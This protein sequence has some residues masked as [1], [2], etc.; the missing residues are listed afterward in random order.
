[1]NGRRYKYILSIAV[2]VAVGF[3]LLI[4]LRTI[5]YN[6]NLKKIRQSNINLNTN[7]ILSPILF[8]VG[9][10][11]RIFQLITNP[12][13]TFTFIDVKSGL[14]CDTNLTKL[15]CSD[16]FINLGNKFN[17][18]KNEFSPSDLV[19][20]SKYTIIEHKYNKDINKKNNILDFVLN[21]WT[22]KN[23][24]PNYKPYN[25]RTSTI[26]GYIEMLKDSSIILGPA[27]K[28]ISPPN[29]LSIICVFSVPNN[30]STFNILHVFDIKSPYNQVK[31][32]NKNSKFFLDINN[33][34]LGPVPNIN[35]SPNMW[36]CISATFDFVNNTFNIFQN[37]CHVITYNYKNYKDYDVKLIRPRFEIFGVTFN[38]FE[39]ISETR[40]MSNTEI[41]DYYNNIFNI[42]NLCPTTISP[43]T[44][45]IPPTTTTMSTTRHPITTARP[46]TRPPTTTCTTIQKCIEIP[47]VINN[48]ENI[49]NNIPITTN[50]PI[51]VYEKNNNSFLVSGYSSE[52][53]KIKNTNTQILKL[54][55]TLS[56]DTEIK[57]CMS[58]S[59]IP[60]KV[61]GIVK[62]NNNL[63]EILPT[64]TQRVTTS[65][66]PPTTTSRS[67]RLPP[68]FTRPPINN[69]PSTIPP[70]ISSPLIFEYYINSNNYTNI[71]RINNIKL[72]F[73]ENQG[74]INQTL[75]GISKNFKIEY[76]SVYQESFSEYT[77][78]FVLEYN[79]NLLIL[80]LTMGITK[81]KYNLTKYMTSCVEDKFWLQPN[82]LNIYYDSKGV[83][84][85][86]FN[87]RVIMPNIEFEDV[88]TVTNKGTVQYKTNITPGLYH[89]QLW[90]GGQSG[91]E[92]TQSFGGNG[93]EGGWY[94]SRYIN[95]SN[96]SELNIVVGK[97]GSG[98]IRGGTTGSGGN[99]SLTYSVKDRNP[100]NISIIASGGGI[101]NVSGTMITG[102]IKGTVGGAGGF[103]N[104]S[105]TPGS[106]FPNYSGKNLPGNG[107]GNFVKGFIGGGGGGGI[108]W[109]GGNGGNGGNYQSFGFS[110]GSGGGGS[111]YVSG[112]NGINGPVKAPGG[113]GG[114]GAVIIRKINFT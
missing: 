5:N 7:T 37:G 3:I 87:N 21:K 26:N 90:G 32:I 108:S 99:T 103:N 29:T 8:K 44:T 75:K 62:Y 67:T 72:E 81:I 52:Y 86:N 101:G 35:I 58:S 110:G 94:T 31:F 83:P 69:I 96:N 80:D 57:N 46:T 38:I 56:K 100:S 85:L 74:V 33:R 50:I 65:T 11:E 113:K 34:E 89:V 95:L 43:T 13:N 102:D 112:E 98:R 6:M 27:D 54:M 48:F 55:I 61:G 51:S 49:N 28:E 14:Y 18:F 20:T 109:L 111:G 10:D 64:T 53:I 84:Y 66:G 97:G 91:E 42:K 114:D 60:N 70:Q 30:T 76:N 105:A 24:S 73:S 82:I 93:G 104:N 92:S 22:Y 1:M 25:A 45:T 59:S 88:Y 19:D 4:I 78:A 71:K 36:M 41:L 23:L 39:I 77:I 79:N 107:G 12:D 106:K 16:K 68:S 2:A 15:K 17:K 9:N 40:I 63:V 47:G